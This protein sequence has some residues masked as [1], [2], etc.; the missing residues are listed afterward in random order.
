MFYLQLIV[1]NDASSLPQL[2][3]LCLYLNSLRLVSWMRPV[4]I[5]CLLWLHLRW[6]PLF[7]PPVLLYPPLSVSLA[8]SFH[9]PFLH[10]CQIGQAL[11]YICILS[12]QSTLLL[13]WKNCSVGN[14]LG[15]GAHTSLGKCWVG[16]M[17]HCPSHFWRLALI[18]VQVIHS[19]FCYKT[20]GLYLDSFFLQ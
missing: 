14:Q 4:E 2:T 17:F 19:P 20:D 3:S 7:S 16:S 15:W 9:P 5:W 13:Y 8:T 18:R 10:F 11:P 6:F 12:Q 1:I